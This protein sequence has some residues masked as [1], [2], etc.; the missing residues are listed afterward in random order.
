LDS[1]L[2]QIRT[3]ALL[4][5]FNHLLEP[6]TAVSQ[7]LSNLPSRDGS[8]EIVQGV[9]SEELGGEEEDAIAIRPGT[10]S[11]Q[12]SNIGTDALSRRGSMSSSF[13]LGRAT[14]LEL[15]Q[16][17]EEKLDEEWG[18]SRIGSEAG[19][20]ENDDM[21]GIGLR[22]IQRSESG[23]LDLERER[24]EEAERDRLNEGQDGETDLLEVLETKSMPDLDRPRRV[25]FAA[26]IL[27]ELDGRLRGKSG[28]LSPEEE[29][30]ARDRAETLMR[31]GSSDG[32]RIKVIERHQASPRKRTR[33]LNSNYALNT[34]PLLP[35]V[36]APPS[37]L[38]GLADTGTVGGK[39]RSDSLF[40]RPGSALAFSPARPR[41]QST[42]SN[43][44]DQRI[45]SYYSDEN[46]PHPR[47]RSTTDETDRT[48]SSF[49]ESD[50]PRPASA[51]SLT[52]S[53]FTSR[54][55]PNI[56]RQQR[57]EQ[58]SERPVFA[59]E[60]GK[61]PN[62][63][64]MPAPL[65]G[66]QLLPPKK[67]RKEGPSREDSEEEEEEEELE[68]EKP[69]RPAGALY[70]RSLMDI[71]EERKIALKAQQRA[72]V[73]GSDGRRGMME[74]RDSPAAQESL[75]AQGALAKL[76]GRV[77]NEDDV[78]K[79]EEEVPLALLP[80]GGALR[81]KK[82]QKETSPT[83]SRNGLSI[84]GPDMLYQ[85]ELAAAR[86]AEE[87]E[88]IEREE[89]ERRAKEVAEIR[90]RKEERR[91]LKRKMGSKALEHRDLVDQQLVSG[92]F[93]TPGDLLRESQRGKLEF[94]SLPPFSF[95]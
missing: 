23:M 19:F 84:F 49:G 70:G 27:D 64:L 12:G 75:A 43:S 89:S 5:P 4:Q 44:S 45:L 10:Y 33:S 50:P 80:A 85:R 46:A 16:E 8:F 95:R 86:K 69:Q 63:I 79:K 1:N 34:L 54:F 87:E 66:Q 7:P 83:K 71:M 39:A 55:D 13:M 40:T 9:L 11:A 14:P 22:Q 94:S 77:G 20:G 28:V 36:A 41:Q 72:Y 15:T 93:K 90:A 78:D 68:E 76:E 29:A 59:R 17:E 65:A 6:S 73:P 37:I 48:P 52:P 92:E 21:T 24:E 26:S 56:I 91:K 81:Q 51:M 47:F 62:V 42:F 35:D 61:P 31:R 60:G 74:W 2:D 67:P 57:E 88:R 3:S 30:D 32:P 53:V 82:T 38:D 58:L 25:S 18:I